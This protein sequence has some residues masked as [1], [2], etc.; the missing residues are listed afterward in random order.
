MKCTEFKCERCKLIRNSTILKCSIHTACWHNAFRWQYALTQ[1]RPPWYIDCKDAHVDLAYDGLKCHNVIS[2][3]KDP[4]V[5]EQCRQQL[6][7]NAAWSRSE[8]LAL[9]QTEL[10]MPNC[11]LLLSFLAIFLSLKRSAIVQNLAVEQIIF[12]PETKLIAR[13]I[14][15]QY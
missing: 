11:E 9:R 12:Y 1:I 4:Y 15:H 10:Y 7:L 5:Y 13:I 2:I 3:G 6:A 8:I 14:C